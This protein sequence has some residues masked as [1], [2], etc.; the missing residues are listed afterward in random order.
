[1]GLNPLLIPGLLY[2]LAGMIMPV[3]RPALY[4]RLRPVL[5][6]SRA[7]WI[8]LAAILVFWIGRNLS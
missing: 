8:A 7:A 5:F 3:I 4:D 1:M 2:I 6:G